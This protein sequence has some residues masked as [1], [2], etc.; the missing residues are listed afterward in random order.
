MSTDVSEELIVSIFRFEKISFDPEDGGD[1]FPETSVDIQRITRHY[2][3][4]DGSLQ[5]NPNS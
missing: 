3:P 2:V 5:K 4:E 1:V